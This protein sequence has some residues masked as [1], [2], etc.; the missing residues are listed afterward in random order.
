MIGLDDL[1]DAQPALNAKVL[2][3]RISSPTAMKGWHGCSSIAP[4]RDLSNSDQTAHLSG[5]VKRLARAIT[6][7][8]FPR[9]R[10]DSMRCIA[11]TVRA[12]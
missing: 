5:G 1:A 8:A 3:E 7:L 4:L 6:S 9:Q 11:G 12:L 2:V 10:Q